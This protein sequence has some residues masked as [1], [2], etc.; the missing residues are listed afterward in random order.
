MRKTR[1]DSFLMNLAP[2]D[3]E[4]LN[5]WLMTGSY[6]DAQARIAAARPDGFGKAIN[7]ASISAYYKSAI[8]PNLLA[9]QEKQARL[10]DQIAAATM[11]PERLE[12]ATLSALELR[13][14]ELAV[15]PRSEINEMAA[16]MR[17]VRTLDH[18][19]R[20]AASPPTPPPSSNGFIETILAAQKLRLNQPAL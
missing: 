6:R 1:S 10:A 4:K 16:L 17:M 8:L 15:N 7:L 12:E 9:I 19:L 11:K 5:H 13:L 2:Q 3:R 18:D 20:E 14:F